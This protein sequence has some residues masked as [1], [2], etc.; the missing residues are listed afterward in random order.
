[1]ETTS[2]QVAT[3]CFTNSKGETLSLTEILLKKIVS[4]TIAYLS[5]PQKKS[6]KVKPETS[7]EREIT[8]S[9]PYGIELI[10][11]EGIPSTVIKFSKKEEFDKI[12]DYDETTLFK[13]YEMDILDRRYHVSFHIDNLR[14]IEWE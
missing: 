8:I 2:V 11:A 5:C 7:L 1:M 9:D 6:W 12:E 3:P 4:V 10:F 13:R 14:A